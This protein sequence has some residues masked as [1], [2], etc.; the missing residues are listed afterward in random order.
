MQNSTKENEIYLGNW[1]NLKV[2]N[3]QE[4]DYYR[5]AY[6][7]KEVTQARNSWYNTWL[8]PKMEQ[9]YEDSVVKAKEEADKLWELVP[10]K[11]NLRKW[12][13]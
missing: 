9:E 8:Y 13:S 11:E 1:G 10:N 6:T 5:A 4:I 7:L 2:S 3:Q 12:H